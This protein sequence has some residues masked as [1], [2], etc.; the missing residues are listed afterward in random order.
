[1]KPLGLRANSTSTTHSTSEQPRD[2]SSL[3]PS[4]IGDAPRITLEEERLTLTESAHGGRG[5][6]V[7]LYAKGEAKP[8][9]GGSGTLAETAEMLAASLERYFGC[10]IVVSV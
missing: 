4:I 1:M 8:V 9:A 10:E 6:A 5:G 2:F 7:M 3:T